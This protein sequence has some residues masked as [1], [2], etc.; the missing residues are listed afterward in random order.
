MAE[1]AQVDAAHLAAA[2]GIAFAAKVATQQAIRHQGLQQDIVQ[3]QVVRAQPVRSAQRNVHFGVTLGTENRDGGS[4]LLHRAIRGRVPAVTRRHGKRLQLA[5][6]LGAEGVQTGEDFRIPVQAFTHITHRLR[7]HQGS[8]SFR[9]RAQ[10]WLFGVL[11]VVRLRHFGLFGDFSEQS[12]K[13]YRTVLSEQ[14]EAWKKTPPGGFSCIVTL[15][16]HHT[17]Q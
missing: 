17:L 3:R 4:V 9:F 14:V 1:L 15:T 8:V 2:L 13:H 6:A 12:R 7:V 5:N 16:R 10:R 11:F